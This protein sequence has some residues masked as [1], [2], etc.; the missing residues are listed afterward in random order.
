MITAEDCGEG[1]YRLYSGGEHVLVR[2]FPSLR[3][4]TGEFEKKPREDGEIA[5]FLEDQTKASDN[6]QDLNHAKV[7][8]N[9]AKKE[10]DDAVEILDRATRKLEWAIRDE[11]EARTAVE[12]GPGL[13]NP[14]TLLVR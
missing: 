9:L 4:D 3:C 12:R 7:A 14:L 11:E 1:V 8:R 13:I 10:F 5:K 2:F 6:R